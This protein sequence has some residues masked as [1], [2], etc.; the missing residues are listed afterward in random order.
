FPM[1]KRSLSF[2]AAIGLAI[3][4]LAAA[5][6]DK[7]NRAAEAARLNN[8]GTAYMNQQ[9]FEKALK[10]FEDAAA[11]DPK[12]LIARL[13]QG[14]ALLNLSRVDAAKPILEEAVKQDPKDPHAW[15]NLGLFYKNSSESQSAIDAFRHAAELDAN[16]PDTWYF[17][18]SAYAQIKQFP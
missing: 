11:A 8:L 12:L 4:I 13:N 5:P 6:Q 15:Y 1:T 3:A 14:I 17:L 2:V 7:S 10:A 18:G 16:D 9:L